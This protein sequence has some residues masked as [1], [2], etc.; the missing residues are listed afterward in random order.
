MSCGD[1]ISDFMHELCIPTE[2]AFKGLNILFGIYAAGFA[3]SFLIM[4]RL[5]TSHINYNLLNPDFRP[6]KFNLNGNG[7][8]T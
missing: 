4:N 3:I 6:E 1:R 8:F 2:R 5:T 7:P